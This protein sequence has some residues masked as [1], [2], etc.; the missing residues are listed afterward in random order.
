M[1]RN[2]QKKRNHLI[3]TSLLWGLILLKRNQ[4]W[5]LMMAVMM[6]TTSLIFLDE[7]EEDEELNKKPPA[8]NSPPVKKA[9]VG[10]VLAK[11]EKPLP[12]SS[13]VARACSNLRGLENDD[14]DDP[15]LLLSDDD[16]AEKKICI[17][18]YTA[19]LTLPFCLLVILCSPYT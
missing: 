3:K 18:I 13:A 15:I 4:S 14:D 7:D 11:Q 9:L 8:R 1:K 19:S 2:P 10:K 12:R 5:I 6:M 17:N 16:K